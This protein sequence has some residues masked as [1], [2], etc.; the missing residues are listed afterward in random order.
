MR[1]QHHTWAS[2]KANQGYSTCVITGVRIINK[3]SF[4]NQITRNGS[5]LA[6]KCQFL[7]FIFGAL[8]CMS[9]SAKDITLPA[10]GNDTSSRFSEAEEKLLGETFMRQVRLELPVSDDPETSSYIQSLGYQLISNSEFYNRHFQ[11]FIVNNAEINAFAG[12]NGYIGIN[13]GLILTSSNES[14]LASVMAHE[15]AHVTQRHLER[16]FDKNDD[17]SLPT[18]AAILTAIVLG[19]ATNINLTEAA[20]FATIAASTESQLSFSRSNELEADHIGVQILTQSY[21]DP[22]SMPSFFEK[23]QQA[24]RYADSQMPEFLRTHPVTTKRIAESRNRASNYNYKYKTSSQA[25]YLTKAKLRVITSHNI[26]QLVK[27]IEAELAE[28]SYQN[29]IAQ[30]YAYAHALMRTKQL[31]LARE[32]VNKLIELDG[33]RIQYTALKANV[34]IEDEN[35]E[36]AFAIFEEALLLNPGNPTLTLHY[37]D[38]LLNQHHPEKAKTVLKNIKNYTTTP[39]YLQLLAKAEGNAGYPGASHQVLA[40]YYLMYD[41]IPSAINHLQQALK[42]KDTSERDRQNILKRIREIK[43]IAILEKQF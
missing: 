31:D 39:T 22:H 23:L 41:L 38:A 15:I 21:F 8:M 33:E 18:A 43:E 14:E 2:C 12:P 20:I 7:L 11:F 32:Q 6:F 29:K 36:K 25:Y 19:S 10:I 37:A 34:E 16:T 28:G 42:E 30:I 35:Y 3:G 5:V 1:H 17:M 24:N 40:E 26:D 9:I 27:R 4:L 13:A